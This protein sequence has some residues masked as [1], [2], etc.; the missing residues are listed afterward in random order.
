MAW[1][2]QG[3][4]SQ[5]LT[6]PVD[7]PLLPFDFA[8]RLLEHNPPVVATS[9]GRIHGVCG[10]W[11]TSLEATLADSICGG[12]RKVMRWIEL[13]RATPCP[14][15]LAAGIDPFLNI[16]TPKDLAKLEA[17]FENAAQRTK[18]AQEH[19]KKQSPV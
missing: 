2:S 13:C 3:G 9:E 17:H 4:F 12:E 16:N 19:P 10:I 7:L 8:A 1:A 15:G 18:D 14:F 11:P 6:V 5:V